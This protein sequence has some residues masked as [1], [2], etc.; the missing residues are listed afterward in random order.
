MI[1]IVVAVYNG[2]K[3]LKRCLE[4]LVKQIKSGI[5]VILVN[6][7]STDNSVQIC[8]EYANGYTGFNVIHK[9]NGG[10]S[11][12]RLE[13][14]K[15]AQGEYI[16]FI[17]C[18]DYVS[19]DLILELEKKIQETNADMIVYDYYLQ[20]KQ[21]DVLKQKINIPSYLVGNINKFDFSL[22]SIA[23]GWD[24]VNEK[25]LKGFL[26]LRCIKKSLITDNMFI[27]ER[28]CFTEDVLFNLSISLKLKHVEYINKPLYYYCINQGSLTNRY[29]SQLWSMLQ[30]RQ[31]WIESFCEENKI[32]TEAKARIERSWWSAIMIAFDNACI[33]KSYINVRREMREIRENNETKNML[34]YVG[35]NKHFLNRVEMIK[36]LLIKYKMYAIYY[37]L[38]R[39][40]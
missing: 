22:A 19:D 34:I 15:Q 8:N 13:G 27:S 29:R 18:D 23:D 6:D 7:G 10:L 26:W 20:I 2:E 5:E 38:K 1:T 4:S 28:K 9:E 16:L 40:C 30:Y 21:D 35:K 25:Y 36:Y 17:D 33:Q 24:S 37:T 32:T 11:S 39:G 31:K 3:Y 12:A 14:F